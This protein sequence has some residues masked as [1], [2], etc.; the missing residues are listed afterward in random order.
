MRTAGGEAAGG[1]GPAAVAE[2]Q[3]TSPPVCRGIVS[4]LSTY[5]V[6][7]DLKDVLSL[8]ALIVFLLIRPQG[9]LGVRERVG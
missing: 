3:S 7:P 2:Y 1:L 5:W 8:G 4:D 9:F 6:N